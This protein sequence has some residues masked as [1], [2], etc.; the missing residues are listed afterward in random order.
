MRL[1]K[2]YNFDDFT[3][4]SEK[5]RAI[6]LKMNEAKK[7]RTDKQ[8]EAKELTAEIRILKRQLKAIE[9]KIG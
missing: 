2:V 5:K 6:K 3:T 7:E 4:L 9:K 1:R 8:T